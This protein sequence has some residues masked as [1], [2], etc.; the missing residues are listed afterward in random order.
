MPA[1]SAPLGMTSS[2]VCRE[3]PCGVIVIVVCATP[4]VASVTGTLNPYTE[5]V[6]IDGDCPAAATSVPPN[7]PNTGAVLSILICWALGGE[8]PADLLLTMSVAVAVTLSM[9]SGVALLVCQ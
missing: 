5:L 6:K 2:T 1:P 7:A 3:P 8:V 4:A 9:P